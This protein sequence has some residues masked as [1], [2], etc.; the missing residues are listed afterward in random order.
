MI[1][2]AGWWWNVVQCDVMVLGETLTFP[3]QISLGGKKLLLLF[4]RGN[5]IIANTFAF[6]P[7]LLP[8]ESLYQWV[9]KLSFKTRY[10]FNAGLFSLL[11][12]LSH[13]SLRR[14]VGFLLLPNKMVGILGHQYLSQDAFQRQP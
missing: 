1:E 9:G 6:F 12:C 7:Y 8:L 2:S 3:R 13:G 5:C 14:A 10:R 11:Q 4:P